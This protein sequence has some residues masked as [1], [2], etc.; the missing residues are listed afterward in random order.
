MAET[1]HAIG[2]ER[3]AALARSLA[4]RLER[5]LRHAVRK[6]QRRLRDG[7]L[8]IPVK[9][10]ERGRPRHLIA[11]RAGS[12]WNLVMPYALASG[13]FAPGSPEARGVLRYMLTHGSRLLGMVRASGFSLYGDPVFPVSGTDQVYGINVSRFLADNDQADQLVLSLYGQLAGGMTPHT[14]VSGEGHTVA[15]LGS[16]RSRAMYQPPNSGANAAFLVTLRSMLVH[17]VAGGLRL[18]Y[19]TPRAWLAPGRRIEV[20]NAPTSVGPL[21]YTLEAREADVRVTVNVPPRATRLSLRLRLPRGTR[22]FDLSGRTGT[23]VFLAPRS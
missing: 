18:A 23:V 7:S 20:R 21:S 2:N 22:T 3:D 16:L 12:Y 13:L 10:L 15:P 4:A 8:F 14:F 19:A 17:E 11:S 9:L 1:W 6:S 5:G